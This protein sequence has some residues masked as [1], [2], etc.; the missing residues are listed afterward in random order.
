MD[1]LEFEQLSEKEMVQ[2]QGGR[3]MYCDG[4]WLWVEKYGLDGDEETYNS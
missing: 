4:E 2:I 3:W 1:A